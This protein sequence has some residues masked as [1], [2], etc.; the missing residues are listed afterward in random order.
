MKYY[1]FWEK[2]SI[3]EF[4]EKGLFLDKVFM[5]TYSIL[6]LFFFRC[7]HCHEF[8]HRQSIINR[9]VAW[10]SLDS[11]IFRDTLFGTYNRKIIL[12]KI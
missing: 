2:Q 8:K 12:G 9:D 5:I 11:Y 7:F 4:W 1:L 3:K 6:M 10:R